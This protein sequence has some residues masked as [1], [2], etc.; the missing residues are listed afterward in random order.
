MAGEEM[1]HGFA[2]GELYIEPVPSA[3]NPCGTVL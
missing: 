1:F 3:K 2:T